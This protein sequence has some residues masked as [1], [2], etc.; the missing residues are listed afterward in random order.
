[1]RPAHADSNLSGG[2]RPP[3]GGSMYS[4]MDFPHPA[5]YMRLSGTGAQLNSDS[6]V[7]KIARFDV[8]VIPASPVTEQYAARVQQIRALNPNIVLLAYFPADFMWDAGGYPV[9]NLWG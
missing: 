7:A 2:F 5:L 1:I 9:G 6:M 8:A 4:R 3:V